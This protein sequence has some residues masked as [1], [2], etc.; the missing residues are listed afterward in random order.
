MCFIKK[1]QEII[2]SALNLLSND[3]KFKLLSHLKPL[4]RRWC[5]LVYKHMELSPVFFPDFVVLYQP[6]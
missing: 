1:V 2:K 5:R 3:G 4:L 6:V